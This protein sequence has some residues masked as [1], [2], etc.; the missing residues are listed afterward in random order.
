MRLLAT[1]VFS[2]HPESV[3]AWGGGGARRTTPFKAASVE[4]WADA[5]DL[6]EQVQQARELRRQRGIGI[7]AD[8]VARRVPELR[9][10]Q[11]V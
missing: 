7:P 8:E 11:R 4:R 6:L 2:P 1:R 10:V 3:D 9:A 5:L